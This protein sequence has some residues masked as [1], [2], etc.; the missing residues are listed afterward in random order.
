MIRRLV[1]IGIELLVA[2][3]LLFATGLFWASYYIDTPEFRSLFT[4]T[5][6]RVVGREVRLNGDININLWPEI[7]L[8]VD[9]LTVGENPDFGTEPF[10]RFDTIHLNVRVLPLLTHRLMIESVFVDGLQVAVIADED[11]RFNLETF[12]TAAGNA[13][14]ASVQGDWAFSLFN[15]EI[16]NTDVELMDRR[17]GRVWRLSGISLHTGEIRADAPIPVTV[18]SGFSLDALGIRADFTLNGLVTYGEGMTKPRL[19]DATLTAT[20][21]GDFLPEDAAPGQLTSRV[22]FDWE[23]RSV[24]L[25]DFQA[26][27]LGLRAEGSLE[28]GDLRETLAAEGHVT[29]RPFVPSAIISRYA[30]DVSVASVD[31]LKSSAFASFVH[32]DESGMRFKELVFTLDDITVRGDLAMA[33]FAAPVFDFDLRG[34]TID[35][36][37]YLLLFYTG[38]P[39]VWGDFNLP[40]FRAFKGKGKIRADGLKVMDTLLSDIRMKVTADK[41]FVFD[42]GAIKKGQAS[43]GGSLEAT[44]GADSSGVPTLA[45]KARIDAESQK[46]GFGFLQRDAASLGGVGTLS[47]DVSVPAVACPPEKRSM[48]IAD[49]LTGKAELRLRNGT[50]RFKSDSGKI[51]EMPY[52]EASLSMGVVPGK[53]PAGYWNPVVDGSVRLRGGKDVENLSM[54]V[55]GPFSV[56]WDES[57]LKASGVAVS[58]SGFWTVLPE[59]ARRV[60]VSGRVDYDTRTHTAGVEDGFVRVLE[61]VVTGRGVL[62]GLNDAPDA[63][64]EVAIDGADPKRIILLLTGEDFPTDDPEALRYWSL[65]ARFQADEHGFALSDVKAKIDGMP[66]T[67]RVVGDGYV[68]PMLS[69]S[70]TGGSLDIDRYL[71]PGADEAI[72]KKRASRFVKAPPVQLPLKF[73][74]ALRLDGKAVL[75]E[76]KLAKIRARGVT[77]DIRADKGEIHVANVLGTAYEGSLAGDWTGRIGEKSLT[78]H[79]VIRVKDMQAGPLTRDLGGRDYVRGASDVDIDVESRGAT[80]DDILQNLNGKLSVRVTSGSFKFSGY[81]DEEVRPATLSKQ[82]IEKMEQRAKARTSFRRGVME[83][84]GENGVFKADKFRLE[85][86]PVLQSYGK[87]WFSLPD[88]SID[89]SIQNDFVVVPSVTLVLSGR[90]TDPKV[91]VPTGRIVNDTVLNILSIPKKSFDFLRDLF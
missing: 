6:S 76:L 33:G 29:I 89:F 39:F 58:G 14:G 73:L 24:D 12:L 59:G 45:M 77:G 23:H 52:D 32:I 48:A 87:G 65:A 82:E 86:P 31:G 34:N 54:D 8:E 42:A 9:D 85:A 25:K 49:H 13:G 51:R 36:D 78:T 3:V 17:S 71:P 28:S 56:A 22:A 15:V 60:N 83:F 67:G 69:F 74:G 41:S 19:G 68:H 64:G 80:D 47:L 88:N 62:T 11:G 38:T 91:S 79:L 35:L 18:G 44:I 37:R 61:T 2:A 50:A 27:L 66:L 5:L 72:E 81:P 75:E 55:Q 16:I 30:P 21:Y 53:G 90:L 4:D 1:L 57:H 63:T 10:A 84:T 40:L 20:V 7:L 70:I 43:V 46:N 26:Q